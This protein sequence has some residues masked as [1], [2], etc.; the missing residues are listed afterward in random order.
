MHGYTIDNN[1]E[2]RNNANDYSTMA[3]WLMFDAA[4]AT[5]ETLD[6]F[7]QAY[8]P[9]RVDRSALVKPHKPGKRRW[10]CCRTPARVACTL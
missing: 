7:L 8:P 2:Q 3:R 5:H 9:S 4:T 10:R 1:D 6:T